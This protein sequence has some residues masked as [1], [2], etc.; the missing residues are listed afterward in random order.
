MTALPDVK[1]RPMGKL[2]A[3]G[4]LIYDSVDDLTFRFEYSGSNLIYAAFA[5]PGADTA[6][7]VWQ[8]SIFAYDG[9]GNPLSRKWPQDV[10]GNA[11]SEYEFSYDMRAAYTYV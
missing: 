10:R 4:R 2:D 5:R 1:T 7:M 9:S 6:D 11:S 8:I 3:Q